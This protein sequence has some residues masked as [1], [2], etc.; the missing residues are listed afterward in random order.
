M[1]N[2]F[3]QDGNGVMV[4]QNS[5]T[6]NAGQSPRAV[7]PP[8]AGGLTML[9]G[10]GAST[11]P[12]EYTDQQLL[13]MWKRWKKE[14]FDQRWIFERQW[15]R[16]IWYLLNRQWIY[17]DSK[18]GQWQDKRLAKWIP[19]PVTNI[20]TTGIDS[21]RASFASIEYGANARP[22]GEDNQSVVSASVADDYAP[23]LHRTHDMPHV[24]NESDFWMLATGNT[25][26]H[27]YVDY[28]RQNGMLTIKSETCV[29]C[30]VTST[31]VQ[32]ANNQQK[33]PSCN[34]TAFMPATN[35]DGS[36]MQT[37]EP[38]P[39]G[40]TT[41]L[42]PF[43]I[44]FPLMYE[45]YS[46]SPYTTR[47][48][49]RDRTYYEQNEELSE[50]AKTLGFSKTPQERT[51]Q[52]FKTLP[53]QGDIGITPPYFAS[54]GAN[55]DSE[56]IV[57]YDVW[58]KPC[59][60]FPEG[61]V[62]RIAGD[63]SP[64]II[65]SEKEKLPGPLPYHSASG[66]PLFPFHHAR[67]R[68]VGGRAL[69]S[70]IIDPAIQKQ[71]QL[72]QIDS[73][74]LMVIGRMANPIWL[75]PKGAEVEK[76]T[77]EPGLVVKWNPLVAGGNAKPERIPGQEIGQSIF[78]YRS[79][80]KNEA[81]EL[82][83]TFDIMQGQKPS[84]TEAYAAMSFLYERAT[85]RHASAFKE[86]GEMY[87][88][89]F[90]DALEIEREFGPDKRI[91]AVMQPT[92]GW[93]FDTFKKSDLSGSIEIIIEDGTLAPKTS[94]GE[95]ASI[96]HLAQ[97][98]L[99]DPS[100]PDQKIAIFQKFGQTRLLPS[101]D[102]QVQE[103]WMNMD[104]FEKFLA[105]PVA[106]QQS[107]Q[108]A[109]VQHAQDTAQGKP[110]SPVGPLVYRRWYNGQI[111]RNELIK[112]C[113]SDRGRAVFAKSP[114]ALQMVDVYLMQID[115][116]IAQAQMGI[117]DA[118]GQMINTQTAV[119]GAGAPHTAGPQPAGAPPA[120]GPGPGSAPQ[121]QGAAGRAQQMGNS[122]QNAAGVG[123]TSS[124]GGGTAQR[125]NAVSIAQQARATSYL[126]PKGAV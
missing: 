76:F 58:I 21:I 30:R 108:A 28:N 109:Q 61:Q 27:T 70:S 88:G 82:M 64:V 43:E 66:N 74:I 19:R 62:I 98:G 26:L 3:T 120:P 124:G 110:L 6:A 63:A 8:P 106:I 47:M 95:R 114:A 45:R 41:A 77:G 4:P 125:P 90:S 10:D 1:A 32:I 111:H 16:D 42:S 122:N 101:I 13:N 33:C 7:S 93:A 119:P 20:L 71:D 72:N 121:Q 22:L 52:I 80:I 39:A 40:T 11:G 34:G 54:G 35:P 107:Q 44:A 115:T 14:S 2:G 83:G 31:E 24:L 56:G 29:Q 85:G 37:Q 117:L 65:H 84:G 123:A 57:E 23:I 112:W 53:F 92:R 79:L 18:R 102:A 104:K 97:L 78:E 105:D 81:Q 49:W 25:W 5:A 116:A 73:H 60:D 94:L 46:L 51:M 55:V 89:W 86:R 113:L 75:E 48:R 38:L 9:R 96:D 12:G 118:G 103:A 91:Q 50:Y 99:I 126:N 68:H 67:Y 15:M 36:P 17:Y 87:K 69:G 59:A 100:D